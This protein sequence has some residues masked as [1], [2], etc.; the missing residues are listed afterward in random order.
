MDK[1][2]VLAIVL[3]TL[4]IVITFAVSPLILRNKNQTTNE[5]TVA[6]ETVQTQENEQTT[7][8][9]ENLPEISE[10]IESEKVDEESKE[11]IEEEIITI[12]TNLA[13][14]KLTNKGGDIL[15]YKLTNH[16]D[17]D[18]KEGIQISDNVSELNR[19]CA[20]SLGPV[21]TKILNENFKITKENDYS[22]LFTKNVVLNGKKYIL[23]KRYSFKNDEYVF[24][25]DVLIHSESGEGIDNEGVAYTI[26]T[27]PQIGPHYNAKQ[28]RY[29]YRQ[30]V[31]YNG[32]KYKK[33][34]LGSGQSLK[35][36]DKDFIWAGIGGKYFVELI[37]PSQSEIVNAGFYDSIVEN[38]NSDA[39]AFI[40]RKAFTESDVNDT[41]YMYFG[42][43]NEKDLKRYNVAENN[44][45]GI[46]GKKVTQCL[47]TSGWLTWLENILKW[48]LELLH[49]IIKNWGVCIILLTIILKLAMF[50]LSRKQSMSTLKMQK[51]QP[52]IQKVQEKYKD[53]QQRMQQ[54]MS[55]IYQEAGYNPASGCLPLI[56]Q[57]LILFAMYNLFNNYFEFRG[58]MFIPHWIE[59][60]S[61]GDSVVTFGFNIPL[62]GNQLR[63][64]PII[65]VATQLLY[66][67]V[68]QYGGAAQGQNGAS[69]KFMTYGM[70]IIF[71]FL[72]YNAPSG[73]L[74]YWTVSN[75]F[76]MVQQVIINRM[77]ADKRSEM[78][79]EDAQKDKKLPPKAKAKLKGRNKS[80]NKKFNK[81][82]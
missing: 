67:K 80:S 12:T 57:F 7:E 33:I 59:D 42:P 43:R 46:G 1:N 62:L 71:F 75:A 25:L 82:L 5:Q 70:P 73:L 28:D 35:R 77:M 76:Q 11:Q 9:I 41:Y 45:W 40:E 78:N 66:G 2:T 19:T 36:Y 47:Q 50:P 72:F 4:V 8:E 23:G 54:E 53:D 29:E 34:N 26:R 37:I 15:S 6:E 52:Q 20:L 39:Q 65:Y 63:I 44:A 18:T 60:L 69:M 17:T 61:K 51:L 74:L 32:S 81:K 68:T 27:A 49:K 58:S 3:S 38:G 16:I 64:L 55:K 56:L 13:E 22:Y 10:V 21:D 30:F 14:I 79:V 48:C 31:A 24:K